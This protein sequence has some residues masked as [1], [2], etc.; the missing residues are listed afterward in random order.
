MVTQLYDGLALAAALLGDLRMAEQHAHHAGALARR[1]SS[2]YLEALCALTLGAVRFRAGAGDALGTLQDALD[3]L[4]Q[5]NAQREMA[6]GHLWLAQAQFAAGDEAESRHHMRAALRLADELGSDAIFVLHARWDAALFAGAAAQEMAPERIH[7]VLTAQQA[8]PHRPRPAAVAALPGMA[9]HAFGAGV[10]A[11]DGGGPVDW[12][13]D[14]AR[15][16]FFLLLQGGARRPEQITL[17]LW[18]DASPARA[19]ANLHAAVYRLRRYVHRQVIPLRDSVYRIHEELITSYDV[20]E[21]ERLLRDAPGAGLDEIAALQRAVDLY[22][23]PFLE[24]LDAE[25]CAQERR[26]LDHLFLVALERLADACAAA[27]LPRESIAAAER[28][29]AHDPLREDVHARI[30]RAY[31]RLGDRAA[32]WRQFERCLRTLREELG[33]APGAELQ[34]LGRRL[35]V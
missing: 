29:L 9:V 21:F 3:A 10:V 12:T 26:R 8:S 22:T 24:D 27:G 11:L 4:T 2:R 7:A 28:L 32:A 19:K 16:L 13:W 25:W 23:A 35:G 33:V 30:I 5:M 31:L 6:R 1:Q 15:E 17:A 18:P 34:A 14:K 20:R